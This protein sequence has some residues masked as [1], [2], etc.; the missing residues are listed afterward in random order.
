M[1]YLTTIVNETKEVI[2]VN[3]AR[4]QHIPFFFPLAP[5]FMPYLSCGKMALSHN[6]VFSP[7]V[8]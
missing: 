7:T 5:A 4:V 8:Y 3:N 6:T 1:L 2:K